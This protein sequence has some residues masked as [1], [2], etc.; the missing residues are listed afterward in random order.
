MS[1]NGNVYVN[2]DGIANLLPLGFQLWNQWTQK[3]A[4]KLPDNFV[5]LD[6][7]AKSDVIMAFLQEKQRRDSLGAM[8]ETLPE[9]LK[10]M[11]G[12]LGNTGVVQSPLMTGSTQP[13]YQTAPALNGGAAGPPPPAPARR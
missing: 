10:V 3:E 6:P 12:V 2:L 8:V 4:F 13:Q 7:G 9:A 1:G 11:L 5:E